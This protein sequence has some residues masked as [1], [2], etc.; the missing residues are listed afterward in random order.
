M[1]KIPIQLL[2]ELLRQRHHDTGEKFGGEFNETRQ[3]ELAIS[4]QSDRFGLNT[5]SGRIYPRHEYSIGENSFSLN[6]QRVRSI[7]QIRLKQRDVVICSFSVSCD[8]Q[9]MQKK[10]NM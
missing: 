6:A 8:R 9:K 4:S 10:L 5:L 1:L 3:R 2:F 7:E